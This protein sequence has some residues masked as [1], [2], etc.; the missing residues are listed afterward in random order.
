MRRVAFAIVFLLAT[1][2][3]WVSSA[4]VAGHSK[5]AFHDI[6][7]AIYGLTGIVAFGFFALML[8]LPARAS[9][10]VPDA[11]APID[12]PK[13]PAPPPSPTP[14][15]DKA[16]VAHPVRSTQWTKASDIGGDSGD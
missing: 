1:V 6:V 10:Q 12:P 11:P 15:R 16:P 4:E 9:Q 13:P 3:A 14:P 2:A 8:T 5:S 7:A